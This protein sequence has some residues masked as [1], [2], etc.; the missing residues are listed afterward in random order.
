VLHALAS[1]P[2]YENAVALYDR[3]EPLYENAVALYDC[4]ELLYENPK[5]WD[6][7]VNRSTGFAMHPDTLSF[8][9][10]LP[11]SVV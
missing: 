6:F 4:G 7:R 1:W 5:A 11:M 10:F 8:G 3:G 2:L 9:D